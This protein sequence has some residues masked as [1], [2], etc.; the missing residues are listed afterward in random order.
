LKTAMF[1]RALFVVR[2]HKDSNVFK[3]SF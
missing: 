1:S 3:G 2:L